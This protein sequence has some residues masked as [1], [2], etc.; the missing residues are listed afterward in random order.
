MNCEKKL[1]NKYRNLIVQDRF[2]IVMALCPDTKHTHDV[3]TLWKKRKYNEVTFATPGTP[4]IIFVPWI[5][6]DTEKT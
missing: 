1:E 3:A 6:L 5:P 4:E 2:T